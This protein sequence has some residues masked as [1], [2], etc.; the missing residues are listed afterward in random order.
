[1]KKTALLLLI[2]M[3]CICL[4]S[5]DSLLQK[6]KSAITGEEISQM[7]EDYV[8]TIEGEEYTYELYK[9]YIKLTAYVGEETEIT[10]P[11]EI[12][13]RPVTVIGSLCFFETGVTS[14]TIS[15]NIDTIEASAFYYA[16]ALTSIVIPD[17]VKN[18]GMRAFG[19][20]N[21]LESVT[22]GKGISEIPD[23]CFNHCISLTSVEIPDNVKSIGLRA[24]SYCDNLSDQI[25]PENIESVGELAFAGC[26]ALEFVT[27]ENDDVSIGADAFVDCENV[28]VIAG[29]DSK[30]YKYCAENNL[31]WSTS[32]SV[33]AITL[34]NSENSSSDESVDVSEEASE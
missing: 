23:Y 32:K 16:D 1:M 12:D 26:P 21:A 18:I 2:A 22:I 33:E 3:L 11:K 17:T 28:V 30:P 15:K 13:D 25:V 5:C 9:T 14:V 29:V 34:G 4:C 19:W 10:I 27:F 7:P 31:R 24:F 8:T 6:A 20:C